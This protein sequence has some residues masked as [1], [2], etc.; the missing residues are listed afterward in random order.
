MLTF[1]QVSLLI[2]YVSFL[3]A[4]QIIFKISA[5]SISGLSFAESLPRLL[6]V[7]TFYLACI[8]YFMATVLW[9]W[10]LSRLPLNQ[11]YPFVTL[12]LILV[13][14]MSWYFFA[15]VPT[16]PYWVGIGMV[17]IGLI[18]IAAASPTTT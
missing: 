7:P 6:L 5:K 17:V 13:P 2:L 10:I 4:G 16:F 14:L 11:A 12:A 8:L 3:S 1:S 15:E 9:V 18:V